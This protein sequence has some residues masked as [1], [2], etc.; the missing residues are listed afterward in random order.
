MRVQ[1]FLQKLLMLNYKKHIVGK[2]EV[3]HKHFF[4]VFIQV[5]IFH[6]KKVFRK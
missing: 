3:R 2:F 6:A 4:I 1:Y 5:V